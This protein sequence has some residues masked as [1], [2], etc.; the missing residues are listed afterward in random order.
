MTEDE[1]LQ[2]HLQLCNRIYLR[3]KAEGKWP[4]VETQDSPEIQT[5]DRVQK[6]TTDL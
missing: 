3:L 5:H 6:T 1:H 4:W 2:K